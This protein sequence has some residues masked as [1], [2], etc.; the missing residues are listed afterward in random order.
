MVFWATVDVSSSDS[1]NATGPTRTVVLFDKEVASLGQN[2]RWRDGPTHGYVVPIKHAKG[3]RVWEAF[4]GQQL[5]EFPHVGRMTDFLVVGGS[6]EG[7]YWFTIRRQRVYVHKL[8]EITFFE[9][10]IECVAIIINTH[11]TDGQELCGM[12]R[13]YICTHSWERKGACGGDWPGT[14][15]KHERWRGVRFWMVS[16]STDNI[17]PWWKLEM[18]FLSSDSS[19]ALNPP[20][21]ACL[22]KTK[23]KK[24]GGNEAPHWVHTLG[25]RLIGC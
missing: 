10:G 17:R 11:R 12:L 19:E 6:L 18:K 3:I 20:N 1:S 13:V 23:K 7:R 14:E 8:M 5:L 24:G 16:C 9:C 2:P 15:P 25:S 22:V 21:V 4:E